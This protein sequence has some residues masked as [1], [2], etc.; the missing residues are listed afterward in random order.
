MPAEIVNIECYKNWEML[1]SICYVISS[2]LSLSLCCLSLSLHSFLI[3]IAM[4]LLGMIVHY[5]P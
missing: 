1:P 4:K 2:S 5:A 3:C